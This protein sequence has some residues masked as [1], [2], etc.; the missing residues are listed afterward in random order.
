MKPWDVSASFCVMLHDVAPIY[1]THVAEFTRSMRPLVGN[2]M[3]AAVVPCWGG[4]PLGEHDRPFLDRV[5]EDYANL[6]LHGFEHFRPGR[7]SFIS[8]IADGKDEMKGLDPAETDRRLSAGQEILERWLGMPAS[9]FIAPAYRVGFATP[10]RLARFGIHYTVGYRQIVTSTGCRLPLATWIWDVS[11]IRILCRLGYRLGELQ[12]RLRP[13]ALP[14]VVLHPLDLE[15][16]FLPQIERTV[17]KLLD[18]GRQPVLLESL[19]FG[20]TP[21][22]AAA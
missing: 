19:G 8:R 12:V 16:G 6:L 17:R 10:Q 15:R 4:V 2:R 3:S 1:A 13:G 20:A 22:P 14:C 7:R 5:R 9:G 18:D 21:L 11:P